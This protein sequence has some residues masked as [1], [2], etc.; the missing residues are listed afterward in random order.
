VIIESVVA[1]VIATTTVMK[2]A[3]TTVTVIAGSFVAP[4]NCGPLKELVLNNLNGLLRGLLIVVLH[5]RKSP[6]SV[7]VAAVIRAKNEAWIQKIAR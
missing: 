7:R 5:P 6:V 4:F 2:A 1:V 3:T